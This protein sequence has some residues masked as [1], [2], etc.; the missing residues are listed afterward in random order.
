MVTPLHKN[1]CPRGYKINLKILVTTFLLNITINLV[2]WSTCMPKVKKMIFKIKN[3][4]CT[5]CFNIWPQTWPSWVMNLDRPFLAHYNDKLSISEICPGVE[6]K[7][8]K[9]IMHLMHFTLWLIWP[10]P[11][12]I[13]PSPRVMTFTIGRPYLVKH[14]YI[15]SLYMYNQC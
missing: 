6:I 11:S 12:T 7:F 2:V 15:L 9:D 5:L 1:P 4:F 8:L 14:N 10:C 13:I 3:A